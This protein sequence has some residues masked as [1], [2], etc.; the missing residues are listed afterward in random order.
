MTTMKN[1]LTGVA[2]LSLVIGAYAA[3]AQDV[4]VTETTITQTE[5]TSTPDDG[6]APAPVGDALAAD[7]EGK[8]F[9]LEMLTQ[10]EKELRQKLI[11]ERF[12]APNFQSLLF[13]PWQ[14]TLLREARAGFNTRAPTQQEISNKSSGGV[15]AIREVSLG[16]IVYTNKDDWTIWLNK[17][18]VTPKALP[19]EALDIK[20]HKEFVELKWFDAQTN[21]VF[22]VRLRPNQ[23]FNL[24]ARMFLPGG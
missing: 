23:R 19:S 9:E 22:P 14:H 3:H 18:R 13:P 20:V 24:D 21:A 17:Q 5:V 8:T 6:T 2:V 15:S 11:N 4:T 10:I 7:D 12:V 16:G 1:I